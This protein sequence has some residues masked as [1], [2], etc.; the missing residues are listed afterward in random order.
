[1]LFRMGPAGSTARVR[2]IACG[3]ALG[4]ATDEPVAAAA[5]GRRVYWFHPGPW[6][7]AAFARAAGR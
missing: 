5:G 3:D 2:D 4:L 1:M 6:S 7:A